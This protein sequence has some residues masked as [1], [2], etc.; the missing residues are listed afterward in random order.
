MGR[1]SFEAS[2]WCVH[3]AVLRIVRLTMCRWVYPM[4][5]KTA[6]NR[7]RAELVAKEKEQSDFSFSSSTDEVA[8]LSRKRGRSSTEEDDNDNEESTKEKQPTEPHQKKQ[9]NQSEKQK[10]LQ[11]E[12]QQQQQQQ[13]ERQ[14]QERQQQEQ[15]Q[16]QREQ[17]QQEQQQQ[18]QREQ[19]QQEQQQQGQREQQQQEQQRA[20]QNE[21]IDENDSFYEDEPLLSDTGPS[22]PVSPA[23]LGASTI[24]LTDFLRDSGELAA[25]GLELDMDLFGGDWGLPSDMSSSLELCGS[26]RGSDGKIISSLLAS[27]EERNNTA[28]MAVQRRC[29]SELAAW[30]AAHA[31]YTQGMYDDGQGGSVQPPMYRAYSGEYMPLYAP[32]PS[33][34]MP[35]RATVPYYFPSYAPVM[36]PS[37]PAA[38]SGPPP[39]LPSFV[40]GGEGDGPPPLPTPYGFYVPHYYA[41]TAG[42]PPHYTHHLPPPRT[43]ATS[44][45]TTGS[46]SSSDGGVRRGDGE[47]R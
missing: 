32:H 39:P 11:H 45:N 30:Q 42:P 43:T 40:M 12:Q 9:K 18:G 25:A 6:I 31:Y 22:P 5:K 20:R 37:A 46:S 8:D 24:S 3:A 28:D 33:M 29:S 26:L 15:Q 7:A 21:T 35:R 27:D 23:A 36:P 4:Q 2:S 14:Q 16:G 38:A 10:Q 17:Q 34:V 41:P 44:T 19:Q 13:H 1:R 47:R